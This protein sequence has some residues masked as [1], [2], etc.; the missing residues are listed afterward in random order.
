MKRLVSLIIGGII[1]FTFVGCSSRL[2]DLKN[3][4]DSEEKHLTETV[5]NIVKA[6]DN[7][8]KELLFSV[9]SENAVNS[10]D[11]DNGVTYIFELYQGKMTEIKKEACPVHETIEDGKR[12]KMIDAAFTVKTDA[13][14]EY[15]LDFQYWM[16]QEI[17]P[18]EKGVNILKISDNSDNSEKYKSTSEYNK[19][20]IY[21]PNWDS[22]EP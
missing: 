12:K 1:M 14:N 15:F 13:G 22:E 21:N 18:F 9:L 11:I 7:K 16:I 2:G 3:E 5:N 20:G 17:S 10:K 4:T 19:S 8:D 6:L